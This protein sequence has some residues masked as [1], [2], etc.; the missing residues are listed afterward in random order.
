MIKCFLILKMLN[1]TLYSGSS[2]NQCTKIKKE[3][4]IKIMDLGIVHDTKVEMKS[5]G[6]CNSNVGGSERMHF[7][8]SE[9]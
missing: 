1:S 8:L 3:F 2:I 6:H 5:M 7:R 4:I 9:D